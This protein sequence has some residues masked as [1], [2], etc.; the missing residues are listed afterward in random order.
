M[1]FTIDFLAEKDIADFMAFYRQEFPRATVLPKMH[2][3][4]DHVIPWLRRWHVGAGL[5]GEQ[6]AESL[7]SAIHKM[8]DRYSSIVNR[9]D[10]LKYIVK[11]HNILTAPSL[12][13]LRPTPKSRG[14]QST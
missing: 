8:D 12:N 4:E 11:E 10:R 5:M 14:R 2:I 6:G 1:K 13:T 9:L 7:H 3:M